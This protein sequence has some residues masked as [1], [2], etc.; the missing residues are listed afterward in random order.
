MSKSDQ[1]ETP[2]AKP[3]PKKRS[4]LAYTYNPDLGLFENAVG[5]KLLKPDLS[6]RDGGGEIREAIASLLRNCGCTEFRDGCGGDEAA[7][8]RG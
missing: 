4:R 6:S 5:W 1:T 7:T 2:P 3:P 8:K